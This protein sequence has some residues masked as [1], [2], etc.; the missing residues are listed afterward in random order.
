M[1]LLSIFNF[2]KVMKRFCI[3]AILFVLCVVGVCAASCFLLPDAGLKRTMMGV[4]LDKMNRLKTVRGNRI[5][6][7]GGS[8]VAYGLD[9]VQIEHALKRPVVNMGLHAG[10]G[11]CFNLASVYPYLRRGDDVFLMIEF[12]DFE[13]DACFGNMEALAQ[14][15][16]VLPRGAVALDKE[17]WIH[18]SRYVLQY[19]A[20]KIINCWKMLPLSNSSEKSW[21]NEQGDRIV[22]WNDPVQ[23]K[24]PKGKYGVWSPIG[25]N[26]RVIGYLRKFVS[27]CASKG[28][29]VW[30]MPPNCLKDAVDEA[31]KKS[32]KDMLMASGL[33]FA[34]ELED[35]AFDVEFMYDSQFHP[36]NKGR[37]LAVRQ[38]IKDIQAALS[39]KAQHDRNGI[40]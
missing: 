34:G 8:N 38:R 28:V 9:S 6:F 22:Q 10:L 39:A 36:N 37:E 30:L 33:P 4:G 26:P 27:D 15:V 31:F 21:Y 29:G 5:V 24:V 2:D 16:D 17:Q 35:Y 7:V 14:A 12:A 20:K 13:G 19:G 18:L 1:P 11:T 3:Q 23:N 25:R 32:Y 40:K